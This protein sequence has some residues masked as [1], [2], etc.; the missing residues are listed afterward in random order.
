MTSA[1]GGKTWSEPRRLPAGILG[2]IKNKP[3][4]LADGTIL[5]PTSD[6][7]PTAPSR[8]RVRFESTRDFGRTWTT[9]SF[10]NDG[11]EIAAI[12]PSILL[13]GGSRLQALGRTRQGRLFETGSEDSGRT[14]GAMTLGPLPNPNSGTDAV[15][16]ADG[17]HLLVY[18]HN[19]EPKG[20]RTPLNV[21]VSRDGKTWKAAL[22]LDRSSTSTSTK[23]TAGDP[24]RNS[25]S[26]TPESCS[27]SAEG[28]GASSAALIRG[29]SDTAKRVSASLLHRN[30]QF[31]HFA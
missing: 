23:S 7:T 25:F 27:G 13:H 5:C 29:D 14:W 21:A 4:Q 11:E 12:Q 6:E 18:N 24:T 31:P 2:P 17:R 10:V 22:V 16:L 9:T 1:D 30:W 19:A 3:V 20:G 15:T 26:I 8:W 28:R